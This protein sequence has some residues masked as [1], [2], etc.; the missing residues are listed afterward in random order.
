MTIVTASDLSKKAARAENNV[1][2]QQSD[3]IINP[4]NSAKL[5]KLVAPPSNYLSPASSIKMLSSGDG[6]AS[7]LRVP[8]K[9]QLTKPPFVP[10]AH[11]EKSSSF[12]S[13]VSSHS[14]NQEQST[15]SPL[16]T[17]LL[18]I[19]VDM[20]G[21]QQQQQQQRAQQQQAV[22]DYHPSTALPPTPPPPIID[23]THV[24]LRTAYS[25]LSNGINQQEH[26]QKIDTT[27]NNQGRERR[28]ESILSLS[29]YWF[30]RSVRAQRISSER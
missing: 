5:V 17:T 6:L 2:I 22:A 16:S 14:I 27:V 24:H 19:P 15:L 11:R 4:N 30:L 21:K 12:I 10:P 20:T 26:S 29:T 3:G 18:D 8:T 23:Q 25:H 7:A 1:I 28:K 9:I 13:T